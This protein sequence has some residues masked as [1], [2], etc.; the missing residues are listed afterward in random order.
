MAFARKIDHKIVENNTKFF[1]I[2]REISLKFHFITNFLFFYSK[3][4]YSIFHFSLFSLFTSLEIHQKISEFESI[5]S[6]LYIVENQRAFCKNEID[7]LPFSRIFWWRL[8]EK[9]SRWIIFLKII[10]LNLLFQTVKISIFKS[11][12]NCI[13]KLNFHLNLLFRILF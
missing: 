2:F 6:P 12:S 11:G 10:D 4:H 13:K 3:F 5:C 9:M 8:S 7:L 1:M